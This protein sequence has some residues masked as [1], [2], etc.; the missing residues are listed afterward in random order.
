[1][2]NEGPSTPKW[3]E[4]RPHATL[5][6]APCAVYAPAGVA[7][8]CS[9]SEYS[10]QEIPTKTPNCFGEVP[11]QPAAS[12]K[13]SP[14]QA[15]TALLL[16][17]GYSFQSQAICSGWSNSSQQTKTQHSLHVEATVAAPVSCNR[18]RCCGSTWRASAVERVKACASKVAWS[19]IVLPNCAARLVALSVSTSQRLSGMRLHQH[20]MQAC[21]T[22]P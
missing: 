10:V 20:Y 4:M 9:S 15:T 13:A 5:N 8:F 11:R 17:I 2:A 3:K 14:V 21:L 16:M 6:T 19:A 12:A 18:R 7:C 1:M 22:W